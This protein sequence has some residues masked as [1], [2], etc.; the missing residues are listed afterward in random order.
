MSLLL[1]LALQENDFVPGVRVED[2]AVATACPHQKLE[3][4]MMP[5][6]RM[7]F[8]VLFLYVFSGIV[9][10]KTG[11]ARGFIFAVESPLFSRGDYSD[12]KHSSEGL[13]L[14]LGLGLALALAPALP[15][16]HK[17]TQTLTL[18]LTITISLTRISICCGVYP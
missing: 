5:Q 9:R 16:T 10:I 6:H 13:G 4:A 15:L 18:N 11:F 17:L 12:E 1:D 3:M 8:R 2:Q 7:R 14:G